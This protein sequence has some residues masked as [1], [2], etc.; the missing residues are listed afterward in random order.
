MNISAVR[1]PSAI[2]PIAM[3]V[4]TLTAVLV[5]IVTSG[6]AP[7]RMMGLPLTFGN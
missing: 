3:S 5:H 7:Q 2:I 4:V 6:A 1:Q